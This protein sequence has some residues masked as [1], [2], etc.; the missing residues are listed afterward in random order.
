V[1]LYENYDVAMTSRNKKIALSS[2]VKEPVS[3]NAIE[4]K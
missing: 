3:Y 2:I 1:M 4:M